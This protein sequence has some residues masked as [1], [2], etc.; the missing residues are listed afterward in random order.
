M[1]E[2]ESDKR[3]DVLLIEDSPDDALLTQEAFAVND[4][5]NL[6]V[7]SDGIE[8]MKFLRREE[9][10][11]GAPRPHLILLDLNLPKKSGIETLKEIKADKSLGMIPVLALTTS[12]ND[13]DISECYRRHVNCY[14]QKPIDFENFVRV[15]GAIE[16]FW[17]SIVV[18]PKRD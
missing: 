4:R 3:F 8:A 13:R 14:I 5:V 9:V 17:L 10:F 1:S 7:V 11:A 15:V 6:Y 12:K 2:K 18:L 16:S